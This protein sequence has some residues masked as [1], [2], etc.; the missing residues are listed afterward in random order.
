MTTRHILTAHIL[1]SWREQWTLYYVNTAEPPTEGGAE[2]VTCKPSQSMKP[3]QKWQLS[4]SLTWA[5]AALCLP[6]VFA[7]RWDCGRSLYTDR[8]LEKDKTLQLRRGEGKK[9]HFLAHHQV[10]FIQ[11]LRG[12]RSWVG[13]YNTDHENNKIMQ[14]HWRDLISSGAVE[15]RISTHTCTLNAHWEFCTCACICHN[16][17]EDHSYEWYRLSSPLRFLSICFLVTTSVTALHKSSFNWEGVSDECDSWK[18][19]NA[20]NILEESSSESSTIKLLSVMA[21]AIKSLW[22]AWKLLCST[23]NQQQ[24]RIK[25]I[26]IEA[27]HVAVYIIATRGFF[28]IRPGFVLFFEWEVYMLCL[29]GSMNFSSHLGTAIPWDDKNLTMFV[30]CLWLMIYS[31]LSFKK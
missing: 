16:D 1:S 8:L 24:Q 29:S 3:E 15:A 2:S 25:V 6:T 18:L 9:A 11:L 30:A 19:G 13:A 28:S 21:V 7:S 27:A 12:R 20:V 10:Y 23:L 31:A 14:E 26:I 4:C 17:C 5:I 22:A